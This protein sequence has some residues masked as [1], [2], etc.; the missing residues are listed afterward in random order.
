MSVLSAAAPPPTAE[1]PAPVWKAQHHQPAPAQLQAPAQPQE[2]PAVADTTART[3]PAT[4]P[5][6]TAAPI[7]PQPDRVTLVQVQLDLEDHCVP[8]S[9][10]SPVP[11]LVSAS[12]GYASP[13]PSPN[14]PLSTAPSTATSPG[15]D[16]AAPL[17][18]RRSSAQKRKRTPIKAPASATCGPLGISFKF[19][20]IPDE[21]DPES[22]LHVTTHQYTAPV[23][24]RATSVADDH[25]RPGSRLS[26][27]SGL[28]DAFSDRS[29]LSEDDDDD[30]LADDGDTEWS[31]AA[32]PRPK[33]KK[34]RKS[35]SSRTS[36]ATAAAAA[37]AIANNPNSVTNR[38]QKAC[39]CCGTTN[40]PLWRDVLKTLPLCNAC[41]IRYKKYHIVCET[42][43]Y[44]PCKQERD[45]RNCKRCGTVLTRTP[46]P[47]RK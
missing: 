7:R 42:C 33:A 3:A 38:K 4:A 25:S 29:D 27:S 35:G 26:M 32:A 44:V 21:A 22:Y 24:S 37:A 23:F 45:S 20:S 28:G 1:P 39:S 18:S 16:P 41:G 13:V 17:S 10:S 12:R 19:P 34:Q 8:A 15:A 47:K 30:T 11:T 9:P 46:L 31:V 5:A 14:S 36:K 43:S 40:T 6:T 2:A